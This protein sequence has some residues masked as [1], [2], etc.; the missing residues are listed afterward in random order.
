MTDRIMWRGSK[1]R[2]I[3]NL[4]HLEL[5]LSITIGVP[6]PKSDMHNSQYPIT[7][8]RD[9]PCLDCKLIVHKNALV[10]LI[11]FKKALQGLMWDGIKSKQDHC[12]HTQ[13]PL[14]LTCC[15]SERPL[16]Q[17]MIRCCC[18]IA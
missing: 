15:Q 9:L 3:G 6:V 5:T 8:S 17:L 18:D 16:P 12:R 11:F 10:G 2:D 1:G 14:Q 13:L 4:P 7:V